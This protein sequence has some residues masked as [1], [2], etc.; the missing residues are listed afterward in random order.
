MT[1]RS[2]PLWTTDM[3]GK[4]INGSPAVTSD[5]VYVPAGR[6]MYA[7]PV[8]CRADGAVCKA[9]WRSSKVG[10]YGI[11]A[12]SPA[13]ANGVIFVSTQGRYQAG[14]RLLA[15]NAYCTN[16]RHLCS[17]I[18]RSAKLGAMVN[19]SP[20]VS[21]GMVFVASNNGMFYAFGLPPATL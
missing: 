17:P 11:I 13:V 6:R 2:A 16:A 10:A 20:A 3:N 9:A 21:N 8:N 7:Y 19:S 12:S 4:Q 5:M 1:L 15:Y 14:G 18:W